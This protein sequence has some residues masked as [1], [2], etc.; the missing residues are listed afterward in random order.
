[1][2]GKFDIIQLF[3]HSPR[4]SAALLRT[5]QSRPFQGLDEIGRLSRVA[6]FSKGFSDTAAYRWIT[7]LQCLEEGRYGARH[8]SVRAS[9]GTADF[10][11]ILS[12][13]ARQD[14][15]SPCIANL[16]EGFSGTAAYHPISIL[17][18]L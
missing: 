15:G 3:A 1:M 17:Q 14:P 4:A 2:S 8:Q 5:L 12:F 18:G 16:P 7:T 13:K 10:I 6:D 9:S 11:H